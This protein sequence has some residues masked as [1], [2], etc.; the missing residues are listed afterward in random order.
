MK[1]ACL[2]LSLFL[3]IVLL[4]S[5][6]EPQEGCFDTFSSN[7]SIFADTECEDCCTY[8]NLNFTTRYLYGEDTNVDS[9]IYY[10]NEV[11]SYFKLRSFYLVMSQF[12]L[13]GDE[14]DYLVRSKT[15]DKL[16]NDD[17]LGLKFRTT[18]N[19][20][21]TITVEDS[22]RSIDFTLGLPVELDT[23]SSPD[24]E[25]SVIELLVDSTYYDEN[26][27]QFY[28]MIVEVEVDS[29]AETI[30]SLGFPTLDMALTDDVVAGTT[31]GNA[32]NIQLSVDFM[33]LFDGVRFQD[34]NE[35][36]AKVLVLE[37]IE[38][39]IEFN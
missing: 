24:N 35:D 12:E 13:H 37:N 18:S 27:D 30:L 1:I 28:K 38:E 32:L 26:L 22:I 14:G 19:S 9:S 10:Q 33:R 7:Y 15:E 11:D 36:E 5:C 39:A 25:Y 3:S 8:P 20:P 23:P 4:D 21:G 2:L 6:V 17:L 34:V 16:I 31:R 29:M